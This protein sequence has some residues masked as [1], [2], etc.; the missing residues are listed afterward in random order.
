MQKLDQ[1]LNVS[2]ADLQELCRSLLTGMETKQMLV[3]G[4]NYLFTG[5]IVTGIDLNKI[6]YI[7]V[8]RPTK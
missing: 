1:G 4:I 2:L 3:R 5:C 7:T 8:I 6:W